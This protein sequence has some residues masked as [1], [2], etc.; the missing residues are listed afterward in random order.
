MTTRL[1][2]DNRV[3]VITG[4]GAGLGRAYAL[5]FAKRG[6][7][8]VVNDID[9]STADNV[10]EEIATISGFSTSGVADYHS[11]SEGDKIVAT[12][13][14][15]F[16]RI[17]V[18]VNN[19]GILRDVRFAKMTINDWNELY[20][21]HLKGTFISTHAAWKHMV[22]QKYGRIVTITSI[23]GICGNFGQANYSA[24]KSAMIGLTKTLAKEGARHNITVN[25]LAPLAASRMT[26]TLLLDEMKPLMS[27]EH[28]APVVSVLAHETCTDSGQIVEVAGGWVSK[29]RFQRAKGTFIQPPF[30]AEQIV[31]N[32]SSVGDF[33]EPDSPQAITETI[34]VVMRNAKLYYLFLTESTCKLLSLVRKR[35]L[36]VD[37]STFT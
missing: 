35:F 27:A 36:F 15:T 5:E 21:V 24:M 20:E 33:S 23:A 18:L 31:E 9:R 17:D 19:A 13:I 34:T 12:A 8:I 25:C 7:K 37:A 14:S 3:V 4:A 28:V 32:W 26:D 10:V 2:F 16:G 1:R 6:A 11:V 30:S 22:A 29:I